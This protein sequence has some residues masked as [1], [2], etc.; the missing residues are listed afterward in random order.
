MYKLIIIFGLTALITSCNLFENKEKKAIQICQKAK[1]QIQIS[2]VL[3]QLGLAKYGLTAGSTWIDYANVL[4][5]Q[6]PNKK[7]NWTAKKTKEDGIYL[8]AFA[9]EDGWG[10]RWEV[11]IEQQ[12]VKHINSNEYLFRKYGQTRFDPEGNFKI[13]NIVIDTIKLEMDNSYY[14]ENNSKKVVYILKAS[15]INKTGKPLTSAEVSGKLQVIFKD[16]TIEG[17]SNWDTGFKN[18]ISKLNPWKPETERDFYL[19]T[20]GIEQ[21]YLD[22]EPEYVFLEVNL[23]AEDPVGFTYDKAIEEYDLKRKWKFLK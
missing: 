4:A 13:A 18:K 11:T 8:V 16:K 15:V 6:N 14:S 23:K 2:N 20:N 10:H 3:G 1:V 5:K 21:I 22:Y 12:I 17:E 9:D 19:K 7:Q